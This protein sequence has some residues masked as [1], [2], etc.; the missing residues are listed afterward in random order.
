[1]V[2]QAIAMK[3][4]GEVDLT[5]TVKG[6]TVSVLVD[7]QAAVSHVF[8]A[9][10]TDGGFGLLARDGEA[11]F[12]SFTVMTDDP[13][14]SAQMDDAAVTMLAKSSPDASVIEVE[15]EAA[16]SAPWVNLLAFA[17]KW[18][19]DCSSTTR[20]GAGRTCSTSWPVGR[21]GWPRS[22]THP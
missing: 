9:V 19:A 8:N 14:F 3:L 11:S 1:M 13:S 18:V 15:A 12:S 10:A 7:G 17:P 2:N 4:K 20:P 6:S 16:S 22:D 21:T 5:V